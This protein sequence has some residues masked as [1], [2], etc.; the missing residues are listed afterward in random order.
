[1]FS[2]E[3]SFFEIILK[4][5]LIFTIFILGFVHEHNFDKSQDYADFVASLILERVDESSTGSPTI[6]SKP[7]PTT[8]STS[9][10]T[11]ISVATST[12]TSASDSASTSAS[13]P[14]STIT[15]SPKTNSEKCR[16]LLTVGE[17]I[18]WKDAG[19]SREIKSNTGE[20][21]KTRD[22]LNSNYPDPPPPFREWTKQNYTGTWASSKQHKNCKLLRFHRADVKSCFSDSERIVV[23]GDSRTRHI[24]RTLGFILTGVDEENG[25][26]FDTKLPSTKEL[27]IENLPWMK[28]WWSGSFDSD[29][30]EKIKSS[31]HK[32]VK[33]DQSS[34]LEPKIVE[35]LNDESQNNSLVIVGEHLLHPL[36]HF[37]H[38]TG[39]IGHNYNIDYIKTDNWVRDN[40]VFP[41]KQ[42]IMPEIVKSLKKKPWLQVVFLGCGYTIHFPMWDQLRLHT[43][44]KQ[45]FQRHYCDQY[46]DELG[47]IIAG[48]NNEFPGVNRILW[49]PAVTEIGRSPDGIPLTVDGVHFN[50]VEAD[51][52]RGFTHWKRQFPNW[53][54]KLN[55]S[56]VHRS[57]VDVIFNVA[58]MNKEVQ[59]HEKSDLCCF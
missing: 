32:K 29:V 19:F 6:I 27:K 16:S 30:V 38:A 54:G 9:T 34:K 37:T 21:T 4:Y 15:K 28:F 58:C 12:T 44:N 11:T 2:D 56:S 46:N 59:I 14:T 42:K 24:F 41:I 20:I 17:W 10:S 7:I 18:N 52:S 45:L 8:V 47:K 53:D 50:W 1:M 22:P 23:I 40:V 49:F 51:V 13:T 25:V 26:W 36:L 3:S 43:P 31:G 35:A 57:I 48:A 55:I 39:I 33:N 5:T